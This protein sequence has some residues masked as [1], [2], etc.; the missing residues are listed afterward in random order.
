MYVISYG[1]IGK[2]R[3]AFSRTDTYN[4]KEKLIFLLDKSADR[5]YSVS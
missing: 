3:T 4:K 1:T 2:K 5:E